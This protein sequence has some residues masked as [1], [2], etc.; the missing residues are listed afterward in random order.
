MF[1]VLDDY[2]ELLAEI[3][4]KRSSFLWCAGHYPLNSALGVSIANDKA[5]TYQRLKSKGIRVPEGEHFFIVPEYREL[6]PKGRELNDAMAYAHKLGFPLF[7]K[8]LNGAMGRYAAMVNSPAELAHKLVE[9]GRADYSAII[10]KVA[11]GKEH[12]IFVLDGEIGFSYRKMPAEIT[13]N[14][15]DTVGQLVSNLNRKLI[16]QLDIQ[17][18]DQHNRLC[19]LKLTAESILKA[20]QTVRLSESANPNIGAIIDD[21]RI[22]VPDKI[23]TWA[24]SVV[25]SLELRIGGI[26]FF[27]PDSVEDD[28]NDFTVIEVNANPM[29]KTAWHLGHT[30]RV[31]YIWE[32]LLK[33][34]FA[35]LL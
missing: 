15:V 5:H 31:E 12:R 3:S 28:P 21:F 17:A 25:Q 10:Q 22:Q 34:R 20:N 29:L 19:K 18:P 32:T 16:A 7:V 13:G 23:K 9:I 26:D 27:A 35:E 1:N 2:T 24:C 33:K 6:R 4:D 11:D 30:E 8:P 14:G